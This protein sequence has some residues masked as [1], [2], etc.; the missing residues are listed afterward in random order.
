M[1]AEIIGDIGQVGTSPSGS[2]ERKIARVQR[3]NAGGHRVWHLHCSRVTGEVT[4]NDNVV[5]D[6]RE[7]D[8]VCRL[9]T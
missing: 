7:H 8:G 5:E 2:C 3:K 6:S 1:G 9:K 4:S